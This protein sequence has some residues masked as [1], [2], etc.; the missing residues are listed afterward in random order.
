MKR[1]AVAVVWGVGLLAALLAYAGGLDRVLP[2]AGAVLAEVAER[3]RGLVERLDLFRPGLVR[4]AAI[5]L[6]V[7]FAALAVMA[8]RQGRRGRTA[9]V[10]VTVAFLWQAA[11]P[12]GWLGAL[13]LSA[14]GA[15]VMT[16][17][18]S[19]RAGKR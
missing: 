12:A 18:L 19:G 7:T 16:A 8:I 3:L 9:L 13:A 5:G 15:A 4:A 10:L 1:N 14:T 6:F 2:F 11:D 17:R